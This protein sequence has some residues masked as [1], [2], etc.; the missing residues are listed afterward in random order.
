MRLTVSEPAICWR[1][2]IGGTSQLFRKMKD[3]WVGQSQGCATGIVH[4]ALLLIR[5][6]PVSAFGALESAFLLGRKPSFALHA[7]QKSRKRN[8]LPLQDRLA[9]QSLRISE[10]RVLGSYLL[11]HSSFNAMARPE[12]RFA[13]P[14]K[15]VLIPV[16]TCRSF[17]INIQ[18]AGNPPSSG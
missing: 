12:A 9:M 8:S 11:T 2:G 10:Q 4:H 3:V 15:V 17:T 5:A 18:S 16:A 6:T 1:G 7:L 14:L 13:L